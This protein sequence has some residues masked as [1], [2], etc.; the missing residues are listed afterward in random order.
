MKSVAHILAGKGSQIYSVESSEPL[1]FAL[2]KM[3]RKNI[4]ALLVVDQDNLVG[5]LSERDVVR[6]MV[7]E[8]RHIEQVLVRELM[9]ERVI[10]VEPRNTTE[11]CMALMTDKRVRHLPVMEQGRLVGVISIGDVV[12][13][14]IEEKEFLIHQLENY[15]TG[16][17]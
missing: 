17:Q 1:A 11:E 8:R 15:I 10:Y 4:G 9:T 14:T 7:N 16:R 2:E 3:A 13:A 5:I 6:R 12:K